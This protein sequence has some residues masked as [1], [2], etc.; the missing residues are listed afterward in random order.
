MKTQA[1]VRKAF[2][3]DNQEFLT[4]RGYRAKHGLSQNDYPAD[5]RAA[6]VDYVDH[7]ARSGLI[8]EK[9]AQRVTL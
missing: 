7:C 1:D 3:S 4:Q 8:T 2:W 6:F 5:V 9:L